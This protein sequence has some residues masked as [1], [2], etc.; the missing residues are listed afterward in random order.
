MQKSLIEFKKILISS[1][2]RIIIDLQLGGGS[3][4]FSDHIDTK[5]KEKRLFLAKTFV[6]C[7]VQIHV[8]F[9]EWNIKSDSIQNIGA[10]NLSKF[11]RNIRGKVITCH[12]KWNKWLFWVH[13]GKERTVVELHFDIAVYQK[14][15]KPSFSPEFWMK[16]M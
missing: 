5:D 11:E 15:P 14:W 8:L 10:T 16:K 7:L 12:K 13:L 6:F 1:H 2:V 3:R 4:L 9:L